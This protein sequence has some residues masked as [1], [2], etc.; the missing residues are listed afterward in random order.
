MRFIISHSYDSQVLTS[1][2]NIFICEDG[3]E[4]ESVE[5]DDPVGPGYLLLVKQVS[6]GSSIYPLLMYRGR[7]SM[8]IRFLW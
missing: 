6:F 4:E 3:F 2:Y 8:R 1:S 5:M 7:R